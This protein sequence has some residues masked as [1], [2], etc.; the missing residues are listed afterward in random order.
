[1]HKHQHLVRRRPQS[2]PGGS[3]ALAK[4]RESANVRIIIPVLVSF[5]LG[6]GGTA[7]WFNHTRKQTTQQ[8][9]TPES[10]GP[11]AASTL[12]VLHSLKSP[13]ELRFYSLLDPAS[14]SNSTQP[15]VE[16]VEGLVSEFQ[17]EANGM[18]KVTRFDTLST[19]TANDALSDG[20]RSFNLDR[21][22]G[23]YL[24]I[25]VEHNGQ[26]D[27]LARLS[28]EWEP[29]LQ[30]DLT[31]AIVSVLNARPPATPAVATPQVDSATIDEVRRAI[32]NL[33]SVSIEEGTR[34]LRETALNEF[35]AAADELGTQLRAAQQRL[36]GAQGG[37]SESEQQAAM[38]QLQ[39][40]QAEQTAKLQRIAA[41]LQAQ[42]AA[43]EQLKGATPRPAPAR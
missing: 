22:E 42:I 30:Y 34:I 3:A 25:A 24:G 15:F 11:L 26:K 16:R 2:K 31:R 27:A 13:V 40:V 20:I 37:G 38:K 23:C 21:G 17:Q 33:A 10:L 8:T 43:L 14:V 18:I 19:S 12:E 5:L 41:R 7:F 1:M 6:I 35:K 36:S 28:P 39:Q 29:A 4:A 32:P 9:E